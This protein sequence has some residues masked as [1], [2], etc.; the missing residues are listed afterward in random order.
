MGIGANNS[1]A[2]SPHHGTSG[3]VARFIA[4]VAK[5]T[6]GIRTVRGSVDLIRDRV[7]NP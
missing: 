2:D 3:T 4:A 6:T 7:S 5:K 1:E